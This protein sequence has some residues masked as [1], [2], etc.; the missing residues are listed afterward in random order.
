MPTHT[1]RRSTDMSVSRDNLHEL[2]FTQ[3]LDGFFIM[4]NDE[5]VEWSDTSDKDAALDYVFA[6]ERLTIA[7][8]AFARHY[9]RPL[10]EMIGMTPADFWAHDLKTGKEAWRG[11]FDQGRLHHESDERRLDGAP[12]R[13]EGHYLCV[14]DDRRWI[15]GHLGIQRDITDRHLAAAEV[16]RSR[17]DLRVLAAHLETVREEER[18]RI[19]RELH[20]ELGQAVT[21]LKL[22]LAWLEHR[23]PRHSSNEL[24][25]RTHDLLGRLDDMMVSVRR[26]ITELRPSVLDELGLADAIE[27]Q[28]QEF[29]TRTGLTLALNVEIEGGVVPDPVASA[30]FR[31][32]QEAL[33]NAARHAGAR[34]VAVS[35][36]QDPRSLALDVIDDGR[37]ITESELRGRRSLGLLGLRERAIACGGTVEI[38]GEPGVGTTVSLRLPLL[39]PAQ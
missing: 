9:H 2:F 28:A 16:S 8:E 7:N 24:G 31:M 27:W 18:T 36:R 14:Y 29:A 1:R 39:A 11:M 37:G 30:V 6:H 38:R 22:D 34:H 23:L 26:I 25:T 32:L 12:V 5:P 33:N 21:A 4:M 35:L 13:I 3:S 17:E 19:A 15:T 20:D 10:S